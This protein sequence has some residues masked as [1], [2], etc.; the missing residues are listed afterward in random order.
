MTISNQVL[1]YVLFLFSWE[2]VCSCHLVRTHQ[3]TTKV[4]PRTEKVND[5]HHC[6]SK[7]TNCQFLSRCTLAHKTRLKTAFRQDKLPPC[8]P[9][10]MDYSFS[11]QALLMY[12]NLILM[13]GRWCQV[14]PSKL[15]ITFFSTFCGVSTHC[16]AGR[17]SVIGECRCH[18]GGA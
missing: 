7:E 10:V 11:P 16:P 14:G 15:F 6:N 4:K 1:F 3:S 9:Q 18:W 8:R 2:F 5:I 12:L 13:W 17:T